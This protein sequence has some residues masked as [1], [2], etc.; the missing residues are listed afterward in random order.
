TTRSNDL[1]WKYK[2][3]KAKH[4][5]TIKVFNPDSKYEAHSFDYIVYSDKAGK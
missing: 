2:L 4:T 1:Y 5:V 3:P